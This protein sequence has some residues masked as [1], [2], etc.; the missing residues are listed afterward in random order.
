[1]PKPDLENIDPQ[2]IYMHARGFYTAEEIIGKISFSRDPYLAAEVSPAVMVISALNIELFLKCIVCIETG[3]T[4]QGHHL[5]YLFGRLS[6][7]TQARAEQVWDT[8]VVPLREPTW[9]KIETAL[10]HGQTLARDLPSALKAGSLSFEKMRYG[11]EGKSAE[12]QFYISDVPRLLGRV[13]IE[14]KPAWANLRRQVSELNN[15]PAGQK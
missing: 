7:A 10:G 5:D 8:E 6:S 15:P 9:K 1:M 11:Y 14:M 3:L 13:I 12:T 4:P 2:L